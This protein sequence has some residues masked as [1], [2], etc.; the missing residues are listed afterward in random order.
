M[1]RLVSD[2]LV[3]SERNLGRLRTAPD[4]L[5]AFTVQPVMFVLLFAFVFGGAIQTPGYDYI[6]FLIPGIIVQNIAF[7]GFVTA[8]GLNE[9]V[10]KGL[11]DR[12]RTLPMARAAVLAGRTLAD[13]VTNLLSLLIL[14]ATA[15][16]IGF[17]FDAGVGE[18]IA[19]IG[20]LMLFGYAFSWVF[21]LLGLMVSSPESANSLGFLA[22]FP[23]T[24]ISSAFVP[25]ESMP[26]GLAWFAEI[27]PFTIVVDAMRALWLDAPAGDAVW[28][29]V[30]WSLV[31]L[32]V[33][34][35]LAVRRYRLAAA[36]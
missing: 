30:V 19:G 8:L 22:V 28:G 23:L 32:A 9:D 26:G 20:L 10:S 31:I 33:F 4:L 21:A 17:S 27:N 29:A 36:R 25:V 15:L 14:L 12:F 11:I 35:P 1:S 24:F 34:A 3:I 18:I 16:I 13:V 6:D 5:I 7:G 2:T